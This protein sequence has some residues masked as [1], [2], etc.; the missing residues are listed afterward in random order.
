MHVKQVYLSS[1]R[2]VCSYKA[3]S[4]RTNVFIEFH[5]YVEEKKIDTV[6]KLLD[7]KFAMKTVEQS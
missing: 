7:S 1:L 6:E 3:W 2:E 5:H 4:C